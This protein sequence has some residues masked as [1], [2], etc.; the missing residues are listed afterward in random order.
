MESRMEVPQKTENRI[1]IWSSN[2]TPGHMPGQNNNSKGYMHPM[3]TAALFTI[4][5]TWKQHKC[6]STNEWTKN[7][8]YIY[9]MEHYTAIKKWNN[10]MCNNTDGLRYYQTQWSKLEREREIPYD[11]IYMWN[12]KYGTNEL[13]NWNRPTDTKNRL[14]LTS[15]G[16]QEGGERDR[17]GLGV[18]G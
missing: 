15:R 6:P 8:W 14:L 18:W 13:Q 17:D 12:L 1:I 10:A 16:C 5:K 7:I 9:A 4:A 2:P 11:I 3:F